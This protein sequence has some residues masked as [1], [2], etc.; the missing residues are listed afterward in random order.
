MAA[1][2]RVTQPIRL[3]EDRSTDRVSLDALFATPAWRQIW[4][5]ILH[6]IVIEMQ[7]MKQ[8]D[9]QAA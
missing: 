3:Y 6:E 2:K 7:Q 5:E 1:K 8:S 9:Q 4:H